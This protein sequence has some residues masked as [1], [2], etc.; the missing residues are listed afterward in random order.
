MYL[1]A[2]KMFFL[3]SFV[4]LLL[5]SPSSADE[6]L[7]VTPHSRPE[8][9]QDF[10]YRKEYGIQWW[11][12]TGHLRDGN[13][14]E[15]GYEL[16]FFTVGIQRR[17]YRS[18]FGADNIY[19]SHFAVTDVKNRTYQYAEKADS[20][21]F[22]FSGADGGRLKVRVDGNTLEGTV[23]RMHIRASGKGSDID[24]VLTPLKPV[25][26]NG[27]GG[28]SRKSEK[29]PLFAS[30]YF[31]YT[32]LRTEGT[33]KVG[34]SFF[35]VK[36]KSWFDRELSSKGLSPEE[37]G[38]DW[39]SIQL[40]DNRE[41]ML[42]LLRKKDGTIDRYSSGTFVFQNGSYRHLTLDDF[43]V[44]ILGRYKSKKTGA[45][46]PAGWDVEIPSEKLSLRIM[47]LV[48]DQEFLGTRSTGNYYW[49]GTCAVEGTEK[50]RAY[51][52]LTGY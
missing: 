11:Y 36:G 47:P 24:L 10:F 26:L 7:S 6:F 33:L 28:Y 37:A 27:E 48:Q 50:G 23:E 3:L 14:R 44:K 2:M 22:G 51:V 25:V 19:I 20:G 30:L 12:F 8:L 39:F 34:G 13:G 4:V 45:D 46:Y 41:I 49:E 17:Q 9:P 18:K 32:D 21:A 42:Y 38:W 29:S 43:R 15:F 1:T 5:V 31:S 35:Q 40:D 16:T 52:E